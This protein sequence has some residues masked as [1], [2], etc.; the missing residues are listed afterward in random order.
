M[1]GTD[2][3]KFLSQVRASIGSG[4]PKRSGQAVPGRAGA[5]PGTGATL[6]RSQLLETF[7]A[8]LSLVG[9]K[10][11]HIHSPRQAVDRLLALVSA[12]SITRAVMWR[13]TL[14]AQLG[15]RVA[16][17]EAGVEC[18]EISEEVPEP[19]RLTRIARA[20]LGVTAA[21]CAV[22]ETGSLVLCS[23]PGQARMVSLL[24]PWHVAFLAPGCLVSSLEALS[25][26][27]R[28]RLEDRDGASN[29]VLITGP[30][31]TGDIELTLT[32]GVHGPKEV[33]VI[34][35]DEEPAPG[36]QDATSSTS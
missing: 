17:A 36:R 4:V 20:D 32:Q 30:S 25:P 14:L 3:A 9:G 28:R 33:H 31:R 34:A 13:H 22:A 35:W 11:Y 16:L 21:D 26:L 6:S 1:F 29:I 18:W 19:E 27:L 10:G 7:L 24:P 23:G 5:S 2:Q 8:E 12:A 15:V